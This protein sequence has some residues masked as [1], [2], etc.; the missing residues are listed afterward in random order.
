MKGA[1]EDYVDAYYLRLLMKF[2]LLFAIM[3]ALQIMDLNKLNAARLVDSTIASAIS[4]SSVV[5]MCA[6]VVTIYLGWAE[7]KVLK[8]ENQ[9]L[10]NI[11][12]AK[13][14][15]F[16]EALNDEIYWPVGKKGL[17]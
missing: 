10:R 3:I 9:I 12:S 16:D 4:S 14:E 2:T 7:F 13:M 15:G 6:L 11:L 17:K 1:F 8:T 5:L